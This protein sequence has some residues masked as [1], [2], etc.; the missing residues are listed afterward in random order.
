MNYP[1]TKATTLEIETK[2][3]LGNVEFCESGIFV[4]VKRNEEDSEETYSVYLQSSE[5]LNDLAVIMDK[6]NRLNLGE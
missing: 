3:L 2:T 1:K 6:I 5:E 4:T